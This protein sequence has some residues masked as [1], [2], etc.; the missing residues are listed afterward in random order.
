MGRFDERE[1]DQLR[2]IKITKGFTRY[3]EG[4]VFIEW[5]NTKVLCNATVEESVPSFKKGSGEGWVTAEYAM[6]PRATHTRNKRDINKL[7]LNPRATEIQR[8]IGRALRGAVDMK[9]LGERSITVDCD[10]IQADGGTRTASI[11]GGFI[12]LALACQSLVERGLIEKVPMH[13]YITAVSVGIVEGK[14]LLDLCYEEDSAAE[15]DMNIIMSDGMGFIEL[16]GTG[17]HGTFSQEQLEEMLGLG[18]KGIL[19]LMEI[20]KRALHGLELKEN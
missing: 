16:Q 12:A 18:K 10:V 4:S 3:A 8:L 6:L 7:K 19:D 9:E 13:H 11:T 5:G 20:Q 1:K 15:V 17:E 14:G 2:P